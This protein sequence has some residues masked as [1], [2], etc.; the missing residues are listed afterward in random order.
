MNASRPANFVLRAA[1]DQ[2]PSPADVHATVARHGV[3]ATMLPN[4]GH[5]L[6]LEPEW[7][8]A[9]E[10]LADR[11]DTLQVAA[12]LPAM[13]TRRTCLRS[14]VVSAL[15]AS[16]AARAQRASAPTIGFL[17]GASAAPWRP[18]VLAFK[19]GLREVGYVEGD[20]V[21]I[22]YR[23]AEHRYEELPS[24]ASELVRRQVSVIVATAG[25]QAAVA[26]RNA[27]STIPI[28]FTSG[29]DPVAL[30]LVQTLGR[31]GG[32]VTGV[33]ILTLLP[34]AKRLELM[35]ELL[36]RDDTVAF[37]INPGAT[38][39]RQYA[40]DAIAAGPAF[41]RNV[42]VF[43]ARDAGQIDEAIREVAR[44]QFRGLI[45]VP[46]PLFDGELAR[47]LRLVEKFGMPSLFGYRDYVVAGGLISYGPSLTEAYRQAG[48]YAGRILAGAK[49]AD[50]PVVQPTRFELVINLKTAEAL[51]LTI[52]RSLLARADELLK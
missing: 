1:G 36:P 42:K 10:A 47:I 21:A 8:T 27:T 26:A 5:M 18:F 37:L 34:M 39:A 33:A 14:L 43:Q 23:W 25:G 22:E 48:I 41:G 2:I 15:V 16:V 35:H 9:A 12:K 45:V 3:T 38:A 20:N 29:A 24:L 50:L 52:P 17:S 40:K 32:N 51:R 19:E 13:T 7:A 11:M 31:P 4:A 30:G 49:P 6:M 46:D 28:V 44:Q